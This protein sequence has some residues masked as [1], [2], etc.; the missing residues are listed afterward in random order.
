M[1]STSVKEKEK[2][3]REIKEKGKM[4]REEKNGNGCTLSFYNGFWI[5]LVLDR[6]KRTD[7]GYLAQ[8]TFHKPS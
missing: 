2:K 5:C 7:E 6:Q 3:N 8:P 4:R 1:K